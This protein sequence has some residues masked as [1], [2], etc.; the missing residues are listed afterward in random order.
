MNTRYSTA[1]IASLVLAGLMA[2]AV[3]PA[4]T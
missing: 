3:P 4:A 1:V 2:G